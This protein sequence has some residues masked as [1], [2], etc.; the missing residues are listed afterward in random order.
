MRGR[1]VTGALVGSL[2]LVS[3][4]A[5]AAQL[6]ASERPRSSGPLSFEGK[7]CVRHTLRADGNKVASART[8]L[9][10]YSYSP[11]SETDALRD[12]G[13]AWS[14]TQVDARGG[15]CATK[16]RSALFLPEETEGHAHAPKAK[17]AAKP[18]RVTTKLVVD[19]ERFGLADGTLTQAYRLYPRRITPAVSDAG[20]TLSVTW[21][22]HTSKPLAFVLGLEFSASAGDLLFGNVGP[23]GAGLVQ[24]LSFTRC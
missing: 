11:L 15:W 1:A 21:N 18:K 5:A 3:T 4:P 24:P 12:Y 17:K 6:D 9:F 7:R 23:F 16:I 19:A 20:R 13:A 22:G 8:C 14:Q 10:L 2:L